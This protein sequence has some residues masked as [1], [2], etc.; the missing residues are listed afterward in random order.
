MNPKEIS[1]QY[2]SK[3]LNNIILFPQKEANKK[4]TLTDVNANR[5]AKF[6]NLHGGKRCFIVGGSPSL[7]NLDLAKLNGEHV[8]TVNR[9]Y[10]LQQKG[11]KRSSYHLIGDMQLVYE[12]GIVTELSEEWADNYFFFGGIDLKSCFGNLVYFDYAIHTYDFFQTDITLPLN[13]SCTVVFTAME[14]AA[15]MGF[16]QIILIGVDLDFVT[17]SGH[18]YSESQG[19]KQRQSELSIPNASKMAHDINFA[20]SFLVSRGID[21]KNASPVES[22]LPFMTKTTYESLF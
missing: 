8:F 15:Y 6:K 21:V 19:E 17:N 10:K 5:L 20:A 9:G 7:N 3:R 22:S 18:A 14:I 16:S 11:L 12:D 2:L 4:N 1:A 13:F